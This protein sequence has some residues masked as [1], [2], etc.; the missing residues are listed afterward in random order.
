MVKAVDEVEEFPSASLTGH[1]WLLKQHDQRAHR[2]VCV[3][4]AL[5]ERLSSCLWDLLEYLTACGK[6]ELTY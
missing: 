5:W 2:A 4:G 1:C 3:V 6:I